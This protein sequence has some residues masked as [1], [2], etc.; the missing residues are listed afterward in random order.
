MAFVIIGVDNSHCFSSL[1]DWILDIYYP[2]FILAG[3]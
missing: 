2:G 1:Q 3:Y